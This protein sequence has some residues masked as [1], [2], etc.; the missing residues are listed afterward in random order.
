MIPFT[1]SAERTASAVLQRPG[2]LPRLLDVAAKSADVEEF[3]DALMSSLAGVSL[4][5]AASLDE[6]RR[7]LQQAR[8]TPAAPAAACP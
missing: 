5:V 7:M 3:S 6:M 2:A 4:P 8:A 1:L